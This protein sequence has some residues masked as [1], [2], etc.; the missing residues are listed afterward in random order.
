MLAL[1]LVCSP[2][3]HRH[4]EPNLPFLLLKLTRQPRSQQKSRSQKRIHMYRVKQ[5]LL[6]QGIPIESTLR[7]SHRR[8]IPSHLRLQVSIGSFPCRRQCDRPGRTLQF[9]EERFYLEL[10]LRPWLAPRTR[11]YAAVRRSSRRAGVNDAG[12]KPRKGRYEE[13]SSIGIVNVEGETE[14]GPGIATT[15][16]CGEGEIEWL[17]RP[18]GFTISVRVLTN[19]S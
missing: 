3:Q 6:K 14:S 2:E 4:L 13:V 1:H 19:Q 16:F 9:C 18:Q 15:Y 12:D 10:V 5:S 7:P 11:R 8:P 17:T